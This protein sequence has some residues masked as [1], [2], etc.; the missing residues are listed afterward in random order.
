MMSDAS[1][2]TLLTV[3][4]RTAL[5]TSGCQLQLS[6][7]DERCLCLR[8]LRGASFSQ[9]VRLLLGMINGV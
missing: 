4:V 2:A 6:A 5:K 9:L 7:V 3:Y 8:S 1:N